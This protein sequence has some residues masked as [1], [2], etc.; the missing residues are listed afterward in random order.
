VPERD[1]FGAW[2]NT[3]RDD[4]DLDEALTILATIPN[5]FS[6]HVETRLRNLR[7][8]QQGWPTINQTARPR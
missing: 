3:H 5:G 2:V 4:I 1:E 8:A 6:N 7:Q